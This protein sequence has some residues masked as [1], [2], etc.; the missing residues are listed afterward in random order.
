MGEA[1][2]GV[3][4]V[5]VGNR[6][7]RD[8]A[9]TEQYLAAVGQYGA[10]FARGGRRTLRGFVN[11]LNRLPRPLMTVGTLGLFVY[12]MAAPAGFA[13]RMEGLALVPSCSG[14]CSAPSYRSTSGRAN[15]TTSAI[16]RG[17]CCRGSSP[18]RVAQLN[19]FVSAPM[20]PLDPD[21]AQASAVA[22]PSVA[23]PRPLASLAAGPVAPEGSGTKYNA[24][25]EEWRS[26]RA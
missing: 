4:E 7:E 22:A 12:A 21:P 6:A 15:Y 23:A 8:A 18:A 10:E 13:I 9:A 5:F 17:R 19:A 26:R 20:E 3:A 2:G 1:V 25:V 14:G 16:A 24:A 11:G